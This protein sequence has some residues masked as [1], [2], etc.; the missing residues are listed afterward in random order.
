MFVTLRSISA[1]AVAVLAVLAMLAAPVV[2]AQ[3]A[4]LF[5]A[6]EEPLG[7]LTLA[8]NGATV[9]GT[10][11]L[12]GETYHIRSVGDGLYAISEVEEPPL[13]CGVEEPHT[14]TDHQH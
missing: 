7:T 1:A 5:M 14:G 13:N 8:V 2:E 4:A 6:V 12:P 11:R 3:T 9:V 10:V